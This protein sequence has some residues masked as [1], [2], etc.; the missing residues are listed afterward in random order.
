MGE[1]LNFRALLLK[2]QDALS[3]SDRKRLHFIL[4][5]Y[6]PADL[7]DDSS[8]GGTLK[9][10]EALVNQAKISEQ[11]VGFLIEV[12]NKIHCHSIVQMLKRHQRI[13]QH[14]KSVE[15]MITNDSLLNELLEDDKV[16]ST[17]TCH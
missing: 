14:Q 11:D 7:R 2:L 5:D 13:Q 8:M 6:I 4:G 3:E 9:L 12:S 10:L 1:Q 16:T 17:G 15:P